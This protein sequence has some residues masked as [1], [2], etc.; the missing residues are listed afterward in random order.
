LDTTKLWPLP[1]FSLLSALPPIIRLLESS[2]TESVEWK[3]ITLAGLPNVLTALAVSALLAKGVVLPLMRR[4]ALSSSRTSD[5]LALNRAE[6]KE[7]IQ[8]LV[9]RITARTTHPWDKWEAP[10]VT[11]YEAGAI[12]AKHG[13]ASPTRGS[14]WADLGGQRVITCI[15][16]LKTLSEGSGGETYFD[17]L[18]VAVPPVA[19]T[20]LVF[21]PADSESKVADERTTH[22]SLPPMEEKWIVQMFGRAQQVSPPLGL[23]DSYGRSGKVSR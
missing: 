17:K 16:Y 19:G 21:F 7:A 6:D 5:A 14:E 13:D 20:A 10:V 9:D 15:C 1:L 8:S 4:M 2:S 12:F 3:D 11:R 18:S 22:E 23:P